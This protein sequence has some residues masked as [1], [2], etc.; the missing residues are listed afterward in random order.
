MSETPFVH[1]LQPLDVGSVRL[2]NRV[3]MGSMH[4][5]FEDTAA[6]YPKLAAYF[7][8]RARGGAGLIVTGGIAPNRRGWLSPFA[9][10]LSARAEL[11]R[12]RLVTEAVRS[13]GGHIC[14]QILHA[15]RYAHHPFSVAPSAIRAP[16]NRYT[17]SALT[18]RAVTKQIDDFVATA[19]LAQEAGYHGVEIMGSEGY[20][21]NQF[22]VSRTNRR[23]DEWG[24]SYEN[25]MRFPLEIV[26]RT[27]L[28]VGPDFMLIF[29]LSMLDLVEGGSEWSEV[30][31]LAR[32]L[33][34]AG[35]SLLNTGIGWHEARVPTISTRVP[36]AAFVW[37]TEHLAPHVRVPLIATNRINDPAV[38]EHV[39]KSGVIAMV[40]M[41][42]PFLAD[43]EFVQKAASGRAD[44]INRCIACNQACLDRVFTGKIVRCLV[45]PRA[46]RELELNYVSVRS[47]RRIAVIGAGPAG[48][49]CATVA[50]ERGHHVTLYESEAQIGGQFNLAK[51]VPGKEEFDATLQYYQRRLQTLNVTLRL[52]TRVSATDLQAAGFDQVVLATGV[53]P[54]R[55]S[56][57]GS[58]DPRVVSYNAVLAGNMELG[59]R[60][61]VLGAGG[62]G[63]DV[64]E[65][66]SQADGPAPSIDIDCFT[67]EWGIDTEFSTRGGLTGVRPSG[68]NAKREIWLLQRKPTPIGRDLG[69]STGWAHRLS[70][71]R[72]G[73]QFMSGVVYES[74]DANGL[75]ISVNNR[76]QTLKADHYVLCIG[77]ESQRELLAAL[78]A[79]QIVPHIIGGAREAGDLDAERA[80]REGAE[81]AATL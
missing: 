27:R 12:H 61:V 75:N 48:L 25:R 30:V 73:V 3:L 70:L 50:A 4:T 42:R 37:V 16:I 32:G 24:G 31:E 22:L 6:D 59:R 9:G 38:A 41:A 8:E 33:E 7:R 11:V 49:S 55:S 26:R 67:S 46:G 47:P 21:I 60:V 58:D 14:M 28:S 65:Y 20:L 56:I 45:N 51:R 2:R 53:R 64:A 39:L 1:L 74:F 43:A 79:L 5:G 29:R 78:T 81:L 57:V 77:Q 44:E 63:F 54:R 10:K 18:T 76:A 17:P 35:I 68:A 71:R 15:G 72:H 19:V 40:S 52:N 23:T 80:I 36:R 34:Q 62:I 69:K 66:L 13:E